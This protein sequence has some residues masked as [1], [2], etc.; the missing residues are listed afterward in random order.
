ME[1]IYN[2]A[3]NDRK[4]IF[5][6]VQHVFPNS[7]NNAQKNSTLFTIQC[8]SVS[9]CIIFMQFEAF[10]VNILMPTVQVPIARFS[11]FI[12]LQSF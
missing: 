8:Q 4:K 12:A 6:R 10:C 11:S 7:Q 3:K 9:M 2:I 5:Y 1:V